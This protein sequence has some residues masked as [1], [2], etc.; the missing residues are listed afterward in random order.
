LGLLLHLIGVEF[1][2]VLTRSV[3]YSSIELG[4]TSCTWKA[5]LF[6]LLCENGRI[7]EQNDVL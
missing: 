2:T 5:E 6:E 3:Q 7:S 4:E 1:C